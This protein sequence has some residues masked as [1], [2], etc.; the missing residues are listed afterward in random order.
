MHPRARIRQHKATIAQ[1]PR[2]PR[3]RIRNHIP[4]QPIIDVRQV[5]PTVIRRAAAS[6]G[7]LLPRR[8]AAARDEPRAGPAGAGLDVEDARDEPGTLRRV[9]VL[10]AGEE[11]R[12]GALDER[13]AE[14]RVERR[15]GGSRHDARGDAADLVGV[16]RRLLRGDARGHHRRGRHRWVRADV[17]DVRHAEHRPYDADVVAAVLPSV[18]EGRLQWL[19]VFGG[20]RLERGSEVLLQR[21]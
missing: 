18:A 13:G 21:A 9:A 10:D 2:R 19:V 3:S 20:E 4:T 7:S 16:V 1:L 15:V 14:G 11:E 5:A 12:H 17:D 8:L 6:T